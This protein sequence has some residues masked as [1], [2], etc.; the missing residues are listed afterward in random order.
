M[1]LE[2]VNVSNIGVDKDALK[3]VFQNLIKNY[4]NHG[5]GSISI[6]VK[7]EGNH[8]TISSKNCAPNIDNA[9]VENMFKR[10]YTVDKSRTKKTTG[11]GLTIVKNLSLKMNSEIVSYVEDS[12]LIIDI[13]F[14]CY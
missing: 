8:A 9:E 14:K 6:I 3:R 5:T 10:F 7:E 13:T 1:Q 11:L 4:L 12:V 2:K